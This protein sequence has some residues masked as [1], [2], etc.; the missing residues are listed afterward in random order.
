MHGCE[1]RVPCKEG[2]EHAPY[3]QV[4]VEP[5]VEKLKDFSAPRPLWRTLETKSVTR[6]PIYGEHGFLHYLCEDCAKKRIK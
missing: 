4:L 5:L 3:V 6:H 1:L 2:M